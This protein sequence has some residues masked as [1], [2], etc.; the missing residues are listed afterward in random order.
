M[1]NHTIP[2]ILKN[3]R[4]IAVTTI[5]S[6]NRAVPLAEALPKGGISAMELTLRTPAALEA[7]HAIS[8]RVPGMTICAGTVLTRTQLSQV[9]DAGARLAVAPGFNPK[10]VTEAE[11]LGIPFAPGVMTPSEIECAFD[12]GCETLKLYHAALAGGPQAF[13]ALTAPYAHLGLQFIHLGGITEQ[14]LSEWDGIKSILSIG[15]SWIAPSE[16]IDTGDWA[17]VSARAAAAIAITSTE[18]I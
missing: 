12:L 10:I 16:L 7:M 18:R 17:A 5:N 4:I 9:I 14:N 15:G 11:Q 3:S 1:L 2:A 8:T 13:R 6:A